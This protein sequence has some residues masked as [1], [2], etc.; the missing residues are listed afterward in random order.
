LHFALFGFAEDK[1]R[2]LAVIMDKLGQSQPGV[3]FLLMHQRESNCH[4]H[5]S[6][7]HLGVELCSWTAS[8]LKMGPIHSPKTNLRRIISQK[9]EELISTAAEACDLANQLCLD[10]G[11][12]TCNLLGSE[13]V[14]HLLYINRID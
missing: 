13:F 3:F 1:V 7:W 10:L 14:S 12:F 9:T 5:A 11:A 8:P 6:L 4:M 2:P